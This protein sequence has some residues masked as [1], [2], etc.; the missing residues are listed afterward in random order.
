MLELNDYNEY[1]DDTVL[2]LSYDEMLNKIKQLPVKLDKRTKGPES[3]GNYFEYTK[4]HIDTDSI[5]I[6][7][8]NYE[9][10]V[11]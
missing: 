4:Y 7:R 6:R 2:D 5:L 1:F 10:T 11:E 3:K 9:K 8:V